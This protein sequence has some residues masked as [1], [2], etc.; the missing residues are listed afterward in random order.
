M[1]DEVKLPKFS[2]L[3]TEFLEAA[4][5][6]KSAELKTMEGTYNGEKI[7]LVKETVLF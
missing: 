2:Y 1:K 5:K 6:I 3:E 4:I 7:L